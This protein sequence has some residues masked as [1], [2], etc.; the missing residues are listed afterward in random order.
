MDF[1]APNR[2]HLISF[3]LSPPYESNTSL[4]FIIQP[5]RM[6]IHCGKVL[7]VFAIWS[8]GALAF[9]TVRTIMGLGLW[10]R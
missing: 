4:L 5:H 3:D 9:C 1:S 7:A 10:V 6:E 8:R 2:V